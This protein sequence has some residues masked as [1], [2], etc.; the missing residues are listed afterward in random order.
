MDGSDESHDAEYD[1]LWLTDWGTL[2]VFDAKTFKFAKK[3]VNSRQYV[4]QKIAGAALS[5]FPVIPY[6]TADLAEHAMSD[7]LK[8][9]PFDLAQKTN[10]IF[11][12][13][14]K[15]HAFWLTREVEMLNP[16]HFI[17]HNYTAHEDNPDDPDAVRCYPIKSC[18]KEL[19]LL[20]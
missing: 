5:F 1:V 18:L 12:L 10:K 20:R 17:Y 8:S 4:L 16:P 2:I 3:E 7:T 11:V 19:N 6:Y 14:D 13:S 15:S 9:L